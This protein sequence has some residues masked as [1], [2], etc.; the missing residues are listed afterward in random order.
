MTPKQRLE[1]RIE[2]HRAKFNGGDPSAPVQPRISRSK[3]PVVLADT[4]LR[5]MTTEQYREWL[6]GEQ[7]D[8]VQKFLE[9]LRGAT[10]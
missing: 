6:Q 7:Q 10:R 9:R 8:E 4:M 5:G 1:K 3:R 2:Q